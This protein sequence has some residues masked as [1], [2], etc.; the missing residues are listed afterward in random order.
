MIFNLLKLAGMPPKIVYYMIP[1]KDKN[2]EILIKFKE[3][4]ENNK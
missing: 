1:K 4:K 3:I 2:K